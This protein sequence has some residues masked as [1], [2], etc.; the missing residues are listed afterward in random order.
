MQA[1]LFPSPQSY[2]SIHLNF[3]SAIQNGSKRDEEGLFACC[4]EVTCKT[5]YFAPNLVTPLVFVIPQIEDVTF[6]KP[7]SY[8]HTAEASVQS[9]LWAQS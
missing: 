9:T 8:N 3:A 4:D 5:S 1:T 6:L 2:S 7:H